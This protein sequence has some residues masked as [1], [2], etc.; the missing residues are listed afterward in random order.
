MTHERNTRA[1]LVFALTSGVLF[2]LGLA[3]SQMVNPAKVI[4]FLDITGKWDPTL[5]FVMLGALAVTT[6]AFRFI[7]KRPHPWFAERFSLPTRKDVEPRL[8]IGAAVFGIG[9]GLAGFCPGPALA[10]LVTGYGSIALFVAAML[11]GA[12]L[13]H[14]LQSRSAA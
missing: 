11:A 7:L 8:V 12:M 3:V 14:L 1:Q 4:A 5:A 10:A 6:P 9:W 2:G 13:Y